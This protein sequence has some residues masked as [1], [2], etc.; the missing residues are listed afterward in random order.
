MW[1]HNLQEQWKM[2]VIYIGNKN[3]LWAAKIIVFGK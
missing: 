3:K 1:K 2:N